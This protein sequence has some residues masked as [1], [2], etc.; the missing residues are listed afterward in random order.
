MLERLRA[1]DWISK[2]GGTKGSVAFSEIPGTI[3]EDEELIPFMNYSY[4]LER[5]KCEG[6]TVK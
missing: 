5:F 3:L 2:E 4:L 6:C 1:L